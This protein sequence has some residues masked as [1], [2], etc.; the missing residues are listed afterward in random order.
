MSD[1]INEWARTWAIGDAALADLRARLVAQAPAGPASISGSEA[2]VQSA[3]RLEAAQKG[4]ILWR[5]NVGALKDER[6]VPVRYGLANDS[7][8][9]NDEVKSADLIGIRPLIVT[10]AHVGHVVGQ[11]VSREC[12]EPGWRY[13]GTAREVAQLRWAQLVYSMGGD[14]GFAADVGTL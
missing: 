1:T 4:L 9:V 10:P 8:A 14:A 7:K 11:F 13:T 2:R 5:N 3:V 12:K 6:G